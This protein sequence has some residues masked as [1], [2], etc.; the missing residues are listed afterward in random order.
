MTEEELGPVLYYTTNNSRVYKEKDQQGMTIHFE[1]ILISSHYY[2]CHMPIKQDAPA[3]EM[4]IQSYPNYILVDNLPL[5]KE[6]EKVNY[7]QILL[8][9][10]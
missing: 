3:V 4:L 2:R 9:L 5:D 6:Q 10:K 8:V 7:H 1:V